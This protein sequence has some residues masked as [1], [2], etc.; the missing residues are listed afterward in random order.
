MR[1]SI[2][3]HRYALFGLRRYSNNTDYGVIASCVVGR[4][5]LSHTS[6]RTIDR[7]VPKKAMSTTASSTSKAI[8]QRVL[9]RID[10]SDV[11]VS[12]PNHIP[13]EEDADRGKTKAPPVILMFGWMD[14]QLPHLYK[15]TEQYN[16][17]YPS[18]TQIIVRIHQSFFW[19][20]EAANRASL[21]PVIKLLRDAGINEH[22]TAEKSGL[23]VHAFSNGGAFAQTSL[24]RTIAKSLPSSA[25][26]PALP[27]QAFVYDSLPGIIDLRITI[28]A[29]TAQIRSPILRSLAQLGFG[30]VYVLGT[31]WGRT[32][33]L[34][35]GQED[36]F[37]RLRRE[38]NEPRLLPQHVPRTY[39][40]SDIDDIIPSESV[41]G[42]AKEARQSIS[43]NA[44]HELVRL[45]KFEGSAHVSHA[46]KDGKRYWD[47]VVR[48]WEASYR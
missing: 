14:A 46:R 40:Y 43:G 25:T 23:L 26:G 5:L 27:A 38:L 45:A 22:T 18:A 11:Y 17:I 44:G 7:L 47:E 36:P 3:Q 37:T 1:T 31:V 34:L 48:T 32:I 21:F 2:N 15:Y 33:G 29:F 6:A 9:N 42:H 30:T 24:A 13:K 19:K 28:L 39:I 41:E 20:G 12:Y 10:G 35:L 16:K 4:R 8:A